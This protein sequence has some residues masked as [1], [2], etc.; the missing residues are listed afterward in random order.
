MWR[1][2][3]LAICLAVPLHVGPAAAGDEAAYLVVD[4]PTCARLVQHL[5]DD[6]VAYRGGVDVR[7]RAVRPADLAP[8]FEVPVPAEVEIALLVPLEAFDARRPRR[9]RFQRPWRVR[10]FGR[11]DLLAR[12]EVNLGRLTFE[13]ASGEIRYNDRPLEPALLTKFRAACRRLTT[14]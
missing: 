3:I 2:F 7:G 9:A 8:E 4:R 12:A 10:R 1:S 13:L 11:R 14:P 5:A 6:D